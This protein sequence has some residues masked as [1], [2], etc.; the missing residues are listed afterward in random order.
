METCSIYIIT[1]KINN[2]KYIGQTSKTIEE[3]WKRHIKDSKSKK[4][5]CRL[6]KNAIV[7]HGD[8]NFKLETLILCNKSLMN[9]YESMFINIYNTMSPNGYNLQS[10][11][12]KNSRLCKETLDKMSQS[13]KGIKKSDETRKKISETLLGRKL[14]DDN[15]RNK[16]SISGKYRNMSV[17]NKNIVKKSLDILKLDNLPMYITVG[18]DSKSKVE[19]ITVRIPDIKIKTFCRKNMNLTDKIK[20]AIQYL[21]SQ[22]ESVLE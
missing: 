2:F 10:G 21:Q 3:R 16:I 12:L 13:Q 9:T 11:G 19:K 8:K 18:I 15:T 20:L 5:G 6:L 17:E 7:E 4:Y 1:N 14:N 22:R